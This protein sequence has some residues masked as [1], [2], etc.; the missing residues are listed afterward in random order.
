MNR[1]V[2]RCKW[3]FCSAAFRVGLFPALDTNH[4]FPSRLQNRQDKVVDL[5]SWW[6]MKFP[7][8][9]VSCSCN[10]VSNGVD[11]G[12]Q[13]ADQ[14]EED[15]E[16]TFNPRSPRANYSLFPLEQLLFCADCQQ[17]K[18]PRCTIEEITCWYCPNCIFE[19]PLSLVKSEGGR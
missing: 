6:R 10:D 9:Y 2:R 3:G 19:V 13:V 16:K 8:T 11:Q 17:I 14:S 15:E 18:C 5:Q 12:T 1:N 7:Y 4:P